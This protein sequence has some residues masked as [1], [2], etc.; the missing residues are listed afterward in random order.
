MGNAHARKRVKASNFEYIAKSTAFLTPRIVEEYFA[1]I[2]SECPHGR[3]TPELFKTIFRL[4]FPERPEEKLDQ[5]IVEMQNKDGEIATAS[6]LM[7]IY[8]FSDGSDDAKLGQIFD[9]FDEDG[10]GSISVAELLNLMAY[11]IEIGEGKSHKVDMATAMAEMYNLG[12][13]DQNEKLEKAEFVRG[14][15]SHEIMRKTLKINTI[16]T[17]LGLL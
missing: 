1:K 8:L 4:A 6:L 11:F 13:S 5:L 9:L 7:L 14:M 12:D 10:N 17:L 3:M 16:D 2:T 15:K